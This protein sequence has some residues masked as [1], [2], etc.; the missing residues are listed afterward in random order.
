MV[1]KLDWKIK[2]TKEGFLYFYIAGTNTFQWA[3]PVYY[4]TA[5]NQKRHYFVEKWR[6]KYDK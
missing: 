2:S 1:K 6:K 4:D 3:F 5:S